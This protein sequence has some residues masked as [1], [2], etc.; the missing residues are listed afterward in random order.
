MNGAGRRSPMVNA[1]KRNLADIPERRGDKR[2][3]AASRQDMS[4][5][6]LGFGAA[7]LEKVEFHIDRRRAA[8]VAAAAMLAG[9][10]IACPA[11][12]RWPLIDEL[13][14]LLAAA[15]AFG[16]GVILI[17]AGFYV[18]LRLL[19]RRGAIVVIDADG[20]HDRRRTDAPLPW[21]R[22]RDIRALDR[23]GR[24]IGIE[25]SDEDGGKASLC[26]TIGQHG[27]PPRCVTVIDTFFLRAATGNRFLDFIL[28]ITALAPIDMSETPVS[29]DILSADARLSRR[30][31][32][33]VFL[34]VAAAAVVPGTAA[35]LLALF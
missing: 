32:A 11:L 34:F 9:G 14:E 3:A 27:A 24:H 21:S 16:G 25:T 8:G 7:P 22:I 2:P 12:T 33:A 20:I 29:A 31:V 35:I 15:V 17:A 26:P 19:L 30:R 23:H 6:S 28:P 13:G 10:L 18:A 5:A 1:F 4:I